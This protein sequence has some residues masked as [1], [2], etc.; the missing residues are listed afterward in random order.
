MVL[1]LIAVCW[2]RVNKYKP[3]KLILFWILHQNRVQNIIQCHDKN[4][5]KQMCTKKLSY[6]TETYLRYNVLRGKQVEIYMWSLHHKL[7]LF[8]KSGNCFCCVP[9]NEI[10]GGSLGWTT[11]HTKAIFKAILNVFLNRLSKLASIMEENVKMIIN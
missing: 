5:W 4:I 10:K 7:V 8:L 3:S 1:L 9:D 2:C 6:N 11:S